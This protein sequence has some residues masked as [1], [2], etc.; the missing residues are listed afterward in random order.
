MGKQ[1][2]EVLHFSCAK[3]ESSL[4]QIWGWFGVEYELQFLLVFDGDHSNDLG[5]I[6]SRFFGSTEVIALQEGENSKI[7][8]MKASIKLINYFLF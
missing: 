3:D 2:L 5:G 6:T 8:V 7:E 1:E 4:C